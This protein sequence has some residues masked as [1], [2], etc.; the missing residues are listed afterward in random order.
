LD[1]RA[2]IRRLW[3]AVLIVSAVAGMVLLLWL[4]APVALLLLASILLAIF[5]RTLVEWTM[6]LT[7]LGARWSLAVVIGTLLALAALVG[8]LLAA[9]ITQEIADAQVQLPNAIAQLQHQLEQTSWG[10]QLVQMLQQPR[11]LFN[12]TGQ[13]LSNAKTFFSITIRGL[14]YIWV[15]LFCGLYLAAQP[16]QY[17]RGFLLLFPP[18]RQARA[19]TVV[20]T[21]GTELRSWL[22][23]QIISMTII[24]ILTWIGLR[25]LGVP[26]A[27]GLAVLAGILDF[28][29]VAGPWVAGIISCL[30]A[31]LKSPMHAVY[32]VCLFLGIHLFEGQV[33]VPQVQRHATRL[34]P[35]LTILGM[36][37]FEMLF[38]F[39]GLFLATPL[40]VFVMVCVKALYVHDVLGY[41]EVDPEHISTNS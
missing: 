37:L 18:D 7:H 28:V 25:L 15:V 21:I 13:L 17:V 23:G 41:R 16:E 38:G 20:R 12:Q 31:L 29:P 22:F 3:A 5:L 14:I 19:E 24:G 2:Y 11:G 8:W 1:W 10:Q 35:V 33:L 34:P 32:V 9:P 36:I 27:E 26:L 4:A 30:L 39:L 6:H 40:L